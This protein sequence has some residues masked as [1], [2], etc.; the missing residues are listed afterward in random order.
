M[1]ELP[2]VETV[3]RGLERVVL[4]KTISEIRVRETRLRF[5]VKPKILRKW[6]AAQSIVA[7]ERRAKYVLCRMS[8]EAHLVIHLGM[9]GRLLWCHHSLPLEKH[10]HIQFALDDGDE[11]RFR[12]PR[13]FG[14]VDAIA[15]GNLDDYVHFRHLGL[16]P[17]SAGFTPKILFEQAQ[18]LARPIKNHLMD[19]NRIVGV[20]NIYANESLFR[21]GIHPET[22]AGRLRLEDWQRL[23]KAVR[24]VLRTAIASGGTTL[25]DFY[26]SD[27]EM[28]Y[29]QQYLKVYSREG[30]ACEDCRATIKRLVQLGRSTYFCPQ[31]QKKSRRSRK[32]S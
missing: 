9:S 27:G 18:G 10:D 30:E 2:E 3:R 12:D 1:P 19:G 24:Y 7:V 25:N 4:G 22:P 6:I 14:L 5:P 29:F 28:G 15:P 17:L 26:N 20:G 16:E 31:C 13:R 32:D 8:N 21:A 23:A 11:L